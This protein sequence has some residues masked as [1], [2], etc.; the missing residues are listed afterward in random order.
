MSRPTTAETAIQEGQTNMIF[1]RNE[2]KIMDF[3]CQVERTS[4]HPQL[5]KVLQR[6]L[7][8]E[9]SKA[10]IGHLDYDF[11]RHVALKQALQSVEAK[12]ASKNAL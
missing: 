6:K 8:R 11:N 10:K 12:I 2:Q 4:D 9:R 5:V 3:H 7:Q 1:G